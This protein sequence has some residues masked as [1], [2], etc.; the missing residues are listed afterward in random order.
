VPDKFDVIILGGGPAG[1]VSAIRASQL[2][3]STAVVER[4]KLGGVCVNIG[5]IPSK[6]LLHSAYVANLINHDAKTLGVEVAGV[7]LDFGAAIKHSRDVSEQNSKGVEFLMKKNKVRVIRGVG[8][9]LSGKKVRVDNET[10]SATK[11]VVIATGSRVKGLPQVGLEIDKS[12]VIS[13]DEAL[14]LKDV[15][16]SIAIVGAGAVGMEFADI[17]SAFGSK[18]SLI[19]VLPRILPLEDADCSAALTRAYKKRKI[20]ILAGAGVKS[21]KVTKKSATLQVEKSG[22]TK[23]I[24]VEKVLMAAGRALNV[25]DIGLEEVGAKLADDGF[26]KVD[27]NLQTTA[28]GYYCIGDI[29]GP[30]MLAHKGS[31]EGVFVAELMAGR[32]PR[33]IKYD[34]IPSV[35]YCHPEVAS[36]GL[37]EEQCKKRRLDYVVGNFPLTANGRARAAMETDGF[38]KIIRDK[39]YGEILGAHIVASHASELI[40]ELALARESEYTVEEVDL[41]IHAHPTLS[42]AV[43]EAALDSL[44]RVIHI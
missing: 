13:S 42:E 10:Y 1:Y 39:K 20:E 23:N 24:A 4:D 36:I 37:T 17:F 15:P 34:N 30:P 2:G 14:V 35:T 43:A 19:E 29:A 3:L 21:A 38:V 18:V 32:K 41:A 27:D 33:T 5:C 6:A 12:T 9:L 16:E 28:K 7:K 44:G 25:E 11:G 40:H 8:R 22:E 31:R 26:V